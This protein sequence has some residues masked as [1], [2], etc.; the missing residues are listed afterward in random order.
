MTTKERVA[1]VDGWFTLDDADPRLL[2]TRCTTL[3]QLLLP[4]GDRAFCRNPSCAGE[5]VRG[6]RRCRTGARCGRSRPTTTRRR[7]RTWRPIRSCRTRSRAV[8][9]PE[10]KMVVLGQVADGVDPATLRIGMEVELVL[11]HAVRGRRPRVRRL[12]VEADRGSTVRC[13]DHDVAV[14]GVGMHPWGKWGR[15]F[16]E[17]GVVA[18]RAAL[19]DAGRRVDRHPVRVRRPTR[20][21]TAI[22]GY[23][24]GAT[25]AQALGWHGAQ[26]AR[27]LRR[28]RVGRDRAV[29]ARG[30]RSSPAC[31]TSRSSSAPTRRR[32]ASS[33]RPRVS[34]ATI[35]TGCASDCSAR[36]TRRTSRCT[37]AGAW[38]CSARRRTT[39]PQV[40]VKNAAPRAARTRTPATARRSPRTRCWRRRSSPIRLR[41]LDICA[42][43]DGAAA[44]VVSS[45]E[46]AQRRGASD[47]VRIA[48]ISTVT[49]SYPNTVI[50]MPELRH[51][52]GGGGAGRGR[53]TFRDVD[54]AAA[55]TRRPASGPTTSTSPRC[56]TCRPRSSSTGTRTSGCAGPARPRSSSTTAR[57]T[58]GGRIP[59]NPSGGLA[60]F[61]EAVPAQAIAQVCEVTWQLRGQAGE[62]QVEG[63]PGRAHRQPGPVRPRLVGDPRPLR[64]R[65]PDLHRRRRTRSAPRPRPGSRR[66]CPAPPLPSGDT[67]E[68]FAL[69]LEWERTLF[70]ARWAVVSWPEEYG[71][72]DASLM[73]WLIFEEE[74]YRAGA[75]QR[76]T[77]NGIFLLAPTMFEFGTAGA[78]G[79]HPAEDGVGRGDRGAR[80]GRSRTRAA[81]SPASSARAVRDEAN[82]GWRLVG[83][84]DLDDARR[85]L[86]APVRPVPQRPRRRAPPRAHLLPRRRSTPGVTVRAVGRLDGDEGFAE[87]FLDDV[88]VPD[89]RR[90]RRRARGLGGRDGDDRLG[91]RPHAAQPGPVPGD[92]GAPRRPVPPPRRRRTPDS[93]PTVRDAVVRAW[94]DAEAYRWQTFWTVTRMIGRRAARAPSRA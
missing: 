70:D 71:G 63:R 21:A 89:A 57:P 76:V 66:T 60:C 65:G 10:E 68:G 87:V 67:R 24:A 64:A 50:E 12:E 51:R 34:A 16:V 90:A 2:G 94:I 26:V 9:L 29:D 59:V 25:F 15:N 27:Q 77:Q 31:A 38:S 44:V 17:Y 11:G 7:R 58:I 93:D 92:R 73:E 72:R 35:P 54:R 86:H 40:K 83:P 3:R 39:S 43:S 42:T 75:P 37:P 18:A 5:R 4:E 23:V 47:P 19:A 52:L 80:A 53:C 55:R 22:P 13:G 82:G 45:I 28:V 30:R 48:A 85:V 69:H 78:A 32:R 88:F 81:T 56:T 6:G 8:E 74:Y 62:R 84:E 46:Y 49:P 20:S 61:G 36:R 41:L 91:A 33:P 1:A 79:P 14:L